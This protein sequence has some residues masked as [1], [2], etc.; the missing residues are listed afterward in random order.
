MITAEVQIHGYLKGHQLLASSVTLSKDDQATVDRLSDVT[1][2]LRPK[3]QFAPYISAYPLPSGS[4]F[5]IARTWQDFTVSRA[6]CVRT[7]SVLVDMTVWALE[8]PLVQ[9]LRLLDINCFPAQNE[10]SSVFFEVE[11]QHKLPSAIEFGASEFL[12]ALFLEDAKPIVIFDAPDPELIATR[13]LIALWPNMRKK[14]A[15]ST[16]ALSPR[17]IGGRYLDLV[18]APSNAKGK[19]SDWPGRRI[20]GRTK[21]NERH[22]WTQKIAHNVFGSTEPSL[23]TSSEEM[24]LSDRERSS[25]AGLRI[26]LLWNELLN[27]LEE[28]PTAVLGLLDIATSGMIRS[29]LALKLLEPRIVDAISRAAPHISSDDGWDFVS[30]L[31]LKT[32]DQHMPMGR[33]A[34]E[35]LA[36]SLSERAPS[37]AIRLMKENGDNEAFTSLTCGIA[38]GLAKG[39]N[40]F[41]ES[42]LVEA[43]FEVLLRLVAN[44]GSLTGRIARND[45][46]I[47]RL[48]EALSVAKGELF[49]A[50]ASTLLPH[51]VENCQ[52]PAAKI[53]FVTLDKPGTIQQIM[54]IAKFND[55][56]STELTSELLHHG[57]V[58]GILPDIREALL[59]LTPSDRRDLLLKR[60]IAPTIVDIRWLLENRSLPKNL[61]ASILADVLLAASDNQIRNLL[62]DNFIVSNFHDRISTLPTSFLS[63]IV[64]QD[65]LP[66]RIFTDIISLLI[67]QTDSI[68][69]DQL[70]EHALSKCLRNTFK[71]DEQLLDHMLYLKGAYLDGSWILREGLGESLSTEVINR[72]L[73]TF[74]SAPRHARERIVKVIPEFANTLRSRLKFGISKEA[75]DASANLLQD[76]ARKSRKSLIEAAGLLVPS[77]LL[78]RN[79]PV[80]PLIAVLFPIIY[81][82]LAESDTT[83]EILKII[84][85]FDWDRCKAART[86]L[87]AAFISSSWKAGDLALTACRCHDADKILAQ[88]IKFDRGLSYLDKIE[89]DLD[90]LSNKDRSSIERA[91]DRI[92]KELN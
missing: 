31:A 37:G 75:I 88:L 56:R 48:T 25:P 50:A 7:K 91:V 85:F 70:T 16:F 14:F 10:A 19:F 21:K 78:S 66:F 84:P 62:T 45:Q 83:P 52:L 90:L 5:V 6:G 43:P 3:E 63:R 4:F 11:T 20:D 60:T 12:E 23:L 54:R 81:Q 18:F 41:I 44:S 9:I 47:V 68:K 51:L 32:Y 65:A 71:G 35:Q 8:P 29:D 64:D 80:S 36:A 76:A 33:K 55:L 92:R 39:S 46:L 87:V 89:R 74:D 58:I 42:A 13:L 28:A 24:L 27:R 38:A 34:V 26:A 79:L 40:P 49:D 59:L 57:Y 67:T 86:E 77:L 61:I 17:T 53:I 2:P 1:G 30:A 15:I 22:R 82:E 73:V 72:N 69:Q